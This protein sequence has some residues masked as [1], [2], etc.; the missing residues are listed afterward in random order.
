MYSSSCDE[1][2]GSINIFEALDTQLGFGGIA[3][4]GFIAK[5]FKKVDEYDLGKVAISQ[6]MVLP[7]TVPRH[8]PSDKSLTRSVIARLRTSSLLFSH[9]MNVFCWTVIH[10]VSN[11][12]ITASCQDGIAQVDS[13][14]LFDFFCFFSLVSNRVAVRVLSG[15]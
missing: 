14:S 11:S 5:D 7:R 1:S 9:F 10:C 6:S 4:E 15:I 13:G 8:T 12:A 3:A 2:E